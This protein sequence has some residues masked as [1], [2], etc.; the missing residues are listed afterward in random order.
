MPKSVH[1]KYITANIDVFDFD[2]NN[3][4]MEKLDGLH[5]VSGLA[6]DPDTANF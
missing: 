1:D 3:E 4:Q 5:G 6:T 2:L